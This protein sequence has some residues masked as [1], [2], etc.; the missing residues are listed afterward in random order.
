MNII[1]AIIAKEN[2]QEVVIENYEL[3]ED[4]ELLHLKD[5]IDD[6][7]YSISKKFMK[8]DKWELMEKKDT[9]SSKAQDIV[10]ESKKKL[11]INGVKEKE[12]KIQLLDH[13][14]GDDVKYHIGKLIDL[15]GDIIGELDTE[16]GMPHLLRFNKESREILGDKIIEN[17][18]NNIKDSIN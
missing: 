16:E 5:K 7:K 17:E 12:T 14:D 11:I 15:A 2:K 10:Y 18:I 9:L 3:I 4:G 1:A 6:K 13:Y 8:S